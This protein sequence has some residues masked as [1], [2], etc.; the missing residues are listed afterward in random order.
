VTPQAQADSSVRPARPS[1]AEAVAAVTLASWR[2]PY[3]ELLPPG[4]LDGLEP[5]DLAAEWREQISSLPT[6]RHVVLAALEG[7][8]VVGY[9]VV[10]PAADPD[11]SGADDLVELL[12]LV[13]HPDHARRGHGSRLLAAAVDLARESGAG[14]LLCWIAD[15]DEPRAAFLRAAGLDCDGATRALDSGAGTPSVGQHRYAASLA[16]AP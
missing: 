8:T 13:V 5:G 15:A 12:D 1:D 4:A 6:S 7:A 16:A 3:A 9:A 14:E 11:T 10:A 2:G